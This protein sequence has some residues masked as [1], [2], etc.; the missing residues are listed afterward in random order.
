[1]IQLKNVHKAFVPK[2]VLDGFTLEDR[3]SVV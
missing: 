1:M 2:R 3:K